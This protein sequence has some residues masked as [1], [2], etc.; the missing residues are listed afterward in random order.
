MKRFDVRAIGGILLIVVGILLLLQNFG[1]LGVVVALIWALIFG[2]G[3]LIFLYVFLTNRAQWWAIIPGFALLGIAVLIALDELLPEVGYVLGGPFFLGMLGLAFW[4]IYF[5]NRKH[6]WAVIP[7]GVLFTLALVAGLSSI[8]E[9]A[10][11]GGVLFLG[12]G[13]TFGLLSLL[14][15]P[16]G[17]MRW[18]LIPA[19]VLLVMGLLITAATTGILEYLWAIAL[20]LAGLYLLFRVFRL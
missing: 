3:G 12:L 20:I 19:A 15:T 4:V 16:Q 9:G 1:I 17:R 6:W 18:A 5:I 14:P 2:A 11:T 10:E 13:L 8:F 7:G